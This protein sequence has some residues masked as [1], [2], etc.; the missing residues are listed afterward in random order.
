MMVNRL[1]LQNV[2]GGVPTRKFLLLTIMC[3]LGLTFFSHPEACGDKFL[4]VGRGVAY[5]RTYTAPRPAS[6]LIYK[7]ANPGVSSAI[8]DLDLQATLG[9]AGHKFQVVE[10]PSAL[11]AALQSGRFD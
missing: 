11:E 4:V 10:T 1:H 6:I 5:Q 7:D 3:V 9:M 8:K 2:R